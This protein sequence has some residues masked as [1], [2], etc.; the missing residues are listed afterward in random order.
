MM[1]TDHHSLDS[2]E[3]YA[4]GLGLGKK[5]LQGLH[6]LSTFSKTSAPS[7]PA[8]RAK[9]ENAAKALEDANLAKK[10]AAKAAAKAK[11]KAKPYDIGRL[12]TLEPLL[13]GWG[14]DM[15]D[16]AEKM[17]H[18]AMQLIRTVEVDDTVVANF[19]HGIDMLTLRTKCLELVLGKQPMSG[20]AAR[21]AFDE[22]MALPETQA[23]IQAG[24]KTQEP[25]PNI[26]T[27]KMLN[28]VQ[29]EL[30]K[31]APESLTQETDEKKRLK[32]F[33]DEV[34]SMVSRVGEQ[35][36]RLGGATKKFNDKADAKVKKEEEKTVV[37][38]AKAKAK[39]AK[40][41][42]AQQSAN[43][44]KVQQFKIFSAISAFKVMVR[45][46]MEEWDPKKASNLP[47]VVK[48]PLDSAVLEKVKSG[49]SFKEFVKLAVND[50]RFKSSGRVAQQLSSPI[51]ELDTYISDYLCS[52]GSDIL[53]YL[54]DA[55]KNYLA[56]PWFFYT[57]GS[58]RWRGVEFGYLPSFKYTFEGTRVVIA[59]SFD[60]IL[61]Y[62][63]STQPANKVFSYDEI[64]DFFVQAASVV[65]G[66]L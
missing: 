39:G 3:F 60:E 33:V 25:H 43:A 9:I 32:N 28:E 62:A 51:A 20:Q 35:V 41:R 18:K 29:E 64:M 26:A 55:E 14:V 16:K 7:D 46:D 4:D 23:Q 59:A 63:K 1:G 2:Q 58:M 31:F 11:A 21:E 61:Q 15:R 65:V 22:W 12:T 40:D 24:V 6:D 17:Y 37:A 27:M 5:A 13:K 8:E 45:I 50:T 19:K 47:V 57:S 34:G 10:A 54:S 30:A 48:A 56:T 52:S 66:E 42:M 36:N 44:P 49:D 38:A 53:R